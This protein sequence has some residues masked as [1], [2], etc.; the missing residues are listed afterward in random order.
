MFKIFFCCKPK[1]ENNGEPNEAKREKDFTVKQSKAKN[2][3]LIVKLEKPYMYLKD[4]GFDYFVSQVIDFTT[5]TATV[6]YDSRKDNYISCHNSKYNEPLPDDLFQSFIE[7]K[8]MKKD[9]LY[10]KLGKEEL[11]GTIFK[12]ILL[13]THKALVMR[14]DK[15]FPKEKAE[16]KGFK[17]YYAI[18]MGLLF[19]KGRN[20]DK[21]KF[22]Y[23]LFKEGDKFNKCPEIDSFL[24]ALFF[25]ASYCLIDS[26]FRLPK[27][28]PSVF[29]TIETAVIQQIIDAFEVTDIQRLVT[30]YNSY[31]FSGGKTSFTYN[32]LKQHFIDNNLGWIFYPRIIRYQLEI[33]NDIK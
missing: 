31:L 33:N 15:A 16:D 6:N 11:N 25:L 30:I 28:F 10:T 2:D 12:E 22:F 3:S 19:C 17:K 29:N 8:I 4:I 26:R 5:L 23:E 21:F 32:E 27:K 14:M 24:A 18:A 20:D 9:P 1:D 13:L 7:N